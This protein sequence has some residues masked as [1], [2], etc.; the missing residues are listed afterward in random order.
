MKILVTNDDGFDCNGIQVLARILKT[1][2][3]VWIM[4]PDQNRSAVSHCISM[5]NPLRMRKMGDQAYTCSGF[6]ADCVINAMQVLLD[7]PPDVVISGINQG[8]NIGTDILY[9]GTAA[10]ARQASLYGIAGIALSLAQDK[11]P[12]NYEP[13]SYFILHN[14]DTLISLCEPDIFLN[15]NAPPLDTFK[16]AVLTS[17]SRR[18]YGDSL[19]VFEAPDGHSYTFFKGGDITT[20]GES[21]CDFTA[22]ENGLVS[23]SRI[24]SQPLAAENTLCED[25]DFKL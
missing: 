19:H 4:A 22:V 21:C 13:L 18:N 24:I 20:T 14:L 6:P 16:G 10:A 3:D 12:W 7:S 5:S 25:I 23:V 17:V 9:S 1:K 8:A 11:L 15:I 2:H